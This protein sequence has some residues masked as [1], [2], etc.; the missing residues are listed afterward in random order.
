MKRKVGE[1]QG[2]ET[3]NIDPRRKEAAGTSDVLK[4]QKVSLGPC[5]SR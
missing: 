2:Q 5:P 1:V 3:E 4:M